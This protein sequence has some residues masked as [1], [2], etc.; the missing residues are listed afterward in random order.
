[1]RKVQT[2]STFI[3]GE[4]LFSKIRDTTEY[5]R[6]I[7]YVDLSLKFLDC[8]DGSWRNDHLS[9]TDLLTLNST[10]Q[11]THIVTSFGLDDIT[12]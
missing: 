8:L 7:A 1:M 2:S 3:L 12:K 11:S 6:A 5:G 9:P 10:Q 4:Y